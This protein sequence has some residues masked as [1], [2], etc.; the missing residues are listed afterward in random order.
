M[1]LAATVLLSAL[2][3]GE[4]FAAEAQDVVRVVVTGDNVSIRSEP[5]SK[6]KVHTQASDGEVF[7]VDPVSVRDRS[8]NSEWYKIL[9]STSVMDDT[10]FQAHK[11]PAYDFSYPYISA[12][13]VRKAPLTDYD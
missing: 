11:L 8:D 7:L 1:V 9:F 3:V 4:V 6:G 5:I 12:K 10:I 13:F 2:G